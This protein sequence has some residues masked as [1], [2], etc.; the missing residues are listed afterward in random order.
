[1]DQTTFLIE[2]DILGEIQST[3]SLI[4]VLYEFNRFSIFLQEFKFNQA[5]HTQRSNKD[6]LKFR[7]SGG[8]FLD[9]LFYKP[10]TL[11]CLN[12]KKVLFNLGFV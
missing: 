2:Q 4:I 10:K 11:F 3:R 9:F 8:S 7:I 12:P 5:E 1:M 6:H